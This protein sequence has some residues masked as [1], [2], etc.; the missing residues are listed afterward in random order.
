[1]NT[2]VLLTGILGTVLAGN[3]ILRR[4]EQQMAKARRGYGFE[5]FVAYFSGGN[6]PEENLRHVYSY[7]QTCQSA[8]NFPVRPNDDLYQVY[9]IVDDDLDDAVMEIAERWRAELPARFEGLRP[10]RTVRMSCIYYSV[11][12]LCSLCLCGRRIGQFVNHRGT[13]N[14]EIA[15]R[16]FG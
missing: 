16:R 5:E 13:E 3:W 7:F 11:Q 10:V 9:G 8:K 4:R 12:P 14:T 15:Q 2:W 1:M 6:I